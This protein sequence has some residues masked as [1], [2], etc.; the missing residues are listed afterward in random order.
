MAAGSPSNYR[1]AIVAMLVG[2]AIG[3]FMFSG[4]SDSPRKDERPFLKWVA[5]AAKNLLW[6]SLMFEEPPEEIQP[7]K[8]EVGEDGYVMVEH[9][10]GW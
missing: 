10:R 1:P 6:I 4:G 5:R 3:W 9:G 2:L 7:V 8:S